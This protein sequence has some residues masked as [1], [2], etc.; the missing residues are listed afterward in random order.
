MIQD[1]SC[2]LSISNINNTLCINIWLLTTLS[3]LQIDCVYLLLWICYIFIRHKLVLCLKL[4]FR[5]DSLALSTHSL[6][7]ISIQ[8]SKFTLLSLSYLLHLHITST[9]FVCILHFHTQYILC[10]L[11]LHSYLNSATQIHLLLIMTE[12]HFINNVLKT[13]TDDE[14]ISD[15]DVITKVSEMF[16]IILIHKND[17]KNLISLKQFI[18]SAFNKNQSYYCI[19]LSLNVIEGWKT[20]FHFQ[21]VLKQEHLKKK[22]LIV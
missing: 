9:S 3:T 12:L 19:W 20:T 4:I 2:T 13:V 1:L 5:T 16:H 7:I 18:S 17:E 10:V 14:Y 15:S 6:S 21:I 8:H 11:I 22:M